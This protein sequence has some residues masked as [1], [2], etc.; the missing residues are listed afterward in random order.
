M[1]Q[2]PH[3]NGI[4]TICKNARELL[5]CSPSTSPFITLHEISLDFILN[6]QN[7]VKLMKNSCSLSIF[8]RFSRHFK[9]STYSLELLRIKKFCFLEMTYF[10]LYIVSVTQLPIISR[11]I[12]LNDP[13]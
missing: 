9:L 13:L 2:R 11:T 5:F 1:S 8:S 12:V 4:G 7:I 3:A 10:A 6:T